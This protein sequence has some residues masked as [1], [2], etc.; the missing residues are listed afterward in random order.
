MIIYKAKGIA[1]KII[2][3]N[4]W[5]YTILSVIIIVQIFSLGIFIPPWYD[6]VVFA[7]ISY[8]LAKHHNFLL[9]V[10]PLSSDFKEVFFFGPIFFYLE[11][12]IINHIAF[13]AFFFRLP[14]YICGALAAIIFGKVLFTITRNKT[15][16]RF[17]LLLFFTNFLVCG[18][19]SC[20]RMEMVTLFFISLSLLLFL[21]DYI[22]ENYSGFLIAYLLSGIAFCLAI[23]TTPRSAFL[24][25]LFAIPLI[26]IFFRGIQTKNIKLIS[27]P[28]IHFF[29]S[30]GIPYLVWYNP[31]LGNPVEI[32][33]YITPS[34]KTQV[35]LIHNHIDV[36]SFAWLLIDF[37]ILIYAFLKRIKLPDYLYGFI[38]GCIVFISI[39]IP[40]SYHHGMIVPVLILNAMLLLFCIRQQ[41]S[42]GFA[43]NFLVVA[44]CIQI[45]FAGMKYAII[46][47]DLPSRNS[48]ALQK[49][50]A[51]NIPQGSRIM[52]SYNYYYGC[53]NNNCAF[54]SIE[55]NT[56]IAT[57]KLVPVT[58]KVDYLMNIYK[59]EFII[60]REDEKE[61]LQPFISTNKFKKIASIT[62]PDGYLTF[63]QKNRGN[64]GLPTATFYNGSIYRRMAE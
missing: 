23:L 41:I 16:S 56:E 17:F 29:L 28:F 6:E 34:V 64:F 21:K 5:F 31:H 20:G 62:I 30:F 51:Q 13:S 61:T 58:K 32:F 25:L 39:V 37:I 45:F 48:N 15:I 14:V 24:Y 3:N 26:K 35:S 38:A 2:S 18:S 27:F 57:G 44:L 59:G 49:I 22:K 60:I 50:I 12:F 52:G 9:N 47:S 46:W 36:N 53:M 19:L 40:W 63:W 10:H 8:S 33:T 54:R 42:A 4:K 1:L 11:A 7:D 55:D 43:S